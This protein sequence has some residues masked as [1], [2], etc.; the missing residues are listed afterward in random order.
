M[1]EVEIS[2]SN[3]FFSTAFLCIPW[4]ASLGKKRAL[5]ATCS[6]FPDCISSGLK[7]MKN[8]MVHVEKII[9]C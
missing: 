4:H 2:A 7:T 5:K 1:Q 3:N 9:E 6:Q 8:L